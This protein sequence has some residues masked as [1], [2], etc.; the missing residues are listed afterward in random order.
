[1]YGWLFRHVVFPTYEARLRGRQTLRRLDDLERSQWLDE[2]VLRE[3]SFRALLE[4]L[5]D[6][7]RDVP[8][9]GRR[10]AEHGVRVRDV[11]APEDLARLP[12]LTK[13]DVRAHRHELVSRRF[14]GRLYESGTGGS[15][16]EPVRFAY[17]HATY[18]R[19]VAAALRAQ[20]WAGGD[21]GEPELHLWGPPLHDEPAL[22]RAKRKLHERVLRQRIESAFDL[23]D[24][25]LD[26]VLE[27]MERLRP[28]V[29]VGYATPLYH[30]ARHV[31]VRGRVPPRVRGIVSSAERLHR[32]QRD[33]IEAAFGAPVFDRYGCRE[34]MLVAA[35]CERHEGLHVSAE[36]VYVELV[37]GGRPVAPGEPG[38]VLLSDLGNRSMPLLRYRNDDVAI[39][40]RTP[41][42]CG[43]GLWTLE[44][45]EG[46]TLDLLVAPDGK[47]LAGELFPHLMKEFPVARFQVHQDRSRA[48][49]VRIVPGA[50]FDQATLARIERKVRGHLP[51][52]RVTFAIVDRIEPTPAG[53][54]RVTISEVPVD[55]AAR[56]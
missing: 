1:M 55:L 24:E 22:A 50:G 33:M 43:R 27:A 2:R 34:M 46:R 54:H 47:L 14:R 26:E 49:T 53:K 38:E 42:S 20:R 45:I 15:T 10:F 16:G 41:C 3:R 37:R 29:V 39:E 36:S 8:F 48:I 17:D 7:E 25:R 44:S 31:V 11:K 51:S 40:A 23:S 21:L 52:A 5:A 13:A 18:E 4:A 56:A 35:E 9:Y 28:R 19:R 32:P 6:A 12:V 30:L